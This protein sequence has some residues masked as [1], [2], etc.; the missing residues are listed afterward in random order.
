VLVVPGFGETAEEYRWLLDALGPRRAIA[1]DVRGRGRSDAPSSGYAWEDHVGDIEAVVEAAGLREFAIVAVSRGVSYGL[2]YALRHPGRVRSFVIGDYH[3]RHVALP[4]E[5]PGQALATTV[6]R[7]VP[8]A[9]RMPPHA[10]R[11]V[12][13]DAVEVPLWHRLPDLDCPVCVIRGTRR[14]V[15]VTD[16]V[17]ERYRRSLPG[18]E[19]HVLDGAGHDL[20]SRDPDRFA[21]LVRAFLVRAEEADP[22]REAR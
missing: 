17:A 5:W 15:L 2:G 10:V 6:L 16:E 20:W 22:S 7:G 14:G 8:L 21:R 9:D 18:A 1:V 3:A 11:G 4:P 19:M 12:Q 13:R